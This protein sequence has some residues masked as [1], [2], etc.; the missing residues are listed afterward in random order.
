MSSLAEIIRSRRSI[1]AFTDQPVPAALIQSLLEVAVYAPNHH[2]TEPWRF[3]L[4]TGEARQK[5]ADIMRQRALESS[6]STVEAER[7][8]AGDGAYAKFMKIPA[9]LAVIMRVDSNPETAEEDLCATSA[10]IQNFLLLAWEQGLGTAWKTLKKDQRFRD[11]L[12]VNA[13]EKVVGIIHIGYPAQI[14]E[15]KREPAAERLTH[16]T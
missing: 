9:F 13:D 7:Q 3:V 2:L 5:Y 6:K 12:G 16:L 4:I 10:L 8:M 14:G 15:G 11:L 1:A